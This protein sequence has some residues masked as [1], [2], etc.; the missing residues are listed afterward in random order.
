MLAACEQALVA[1][2]SFDL[3]A[4]LMDLIQVGAVIGFE[5]AREP[6]KP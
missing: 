6:L 5:T 1:D 3:A 4:N 2:P